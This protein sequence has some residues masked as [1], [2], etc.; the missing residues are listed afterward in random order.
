MKYKQLYLT[1]IELDD[2]IETMEE[3]GDIT[4]TN[5]LIN[6]REG[7]IL[8]TSSK[9]TGTF[10]TPMRSTARVVALDYGALE[11]LRP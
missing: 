2:V 3:Y 4:I 7:K 1:D 11:C 5:A 10:I 8:H 6:I 9:A